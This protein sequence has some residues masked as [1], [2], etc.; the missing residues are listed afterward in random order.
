MLLVVIDDEQAQ[1][2]QAGQQAAK[3]PKRQRFADA[4]QRS[5]RGKHEEKRGGKHA[6]PAFQGVI[7]GKGLRAGV[8]GV[9]W[10][11]HSLVVAVSVMTGIRSMNFTRYLRFGAS[12]GS[13]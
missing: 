5:Y 4:R 8:K 10:F 9:G 12:G 1:D 11:N 2:Q 3:N 7:L 13:C 6:L